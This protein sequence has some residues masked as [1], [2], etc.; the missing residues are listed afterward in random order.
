MRFGKILRETLEEILKKQNK[1]ALL[2]N[3]MKDIM[4]FII[5]IM[6]IENLRNI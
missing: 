1:T 2:L 5:C 3:L 4:N 6:S